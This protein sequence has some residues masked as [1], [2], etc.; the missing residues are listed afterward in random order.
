MGNLASFLT[1]QKK[2]IFNLER[3]NVEM[4]LHGQDAILAAMSAQP[5][6]I[7]EIKR[8]Q[9]EDEF[10]KK[11]CDEM[12]TKPKPGFLIKNSVLKFQDRL[13]VPIVP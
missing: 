6:L 3:M 2:L 10:L 5:A 4:V 12:E 7:E 9:V 13:C 8:R 11:I 1:R